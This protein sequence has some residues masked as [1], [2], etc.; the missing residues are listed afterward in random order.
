MG[1][2]RAWGTCRFSLSLCL[3]MY[4]GLSAACLSV[5]LCQSSSVF[6][7]LCMSVCL[8]VCLYVCLSL[9][10]SVCVCLSVGLSVFLSVLHIGP[11]LMKGRQSDTYHS[12]SGAHSFIHIHS[13]SFTH[14][15][16]GDR[17][18]EL[19]RQYEEMWRVRSEQRDG[20]S[21]I[22]GVGKLSTTI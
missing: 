12:Q 21:L 7:C 5:W 16:V 2:D 8:S 18:I 11:S 14:P 15:A 6:V 22:H 1:R 9:C 3:C 4:A 19:D 20:S 17:A 10:L 13:Y